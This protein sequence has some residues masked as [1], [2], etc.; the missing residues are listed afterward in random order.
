MARREVVL[1][2]RVACFEKSCRLHARQME[3]CME[4]MVEEGGKS[5]VAMHAPFQAFD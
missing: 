4:S 2:V 5:E 1:K 3:S